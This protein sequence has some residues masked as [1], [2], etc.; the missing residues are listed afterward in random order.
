M[1]PFKPQIRKAERKKAKMRLG[2]IGVSGS[3]KTFS[4][5]QIAFGMGGKV[6]LIDTE[7]G[8]GELYSHMGD[9]DVITLEPPYTT[10]KYRDAMKA[11][12]DAGYGTI[13]LD[14][15]THAWSG[16]GGLLEKQG[17]LEASGKYK[18]SYASWREITPEHNLFIEEMLNSPCNVIATM[19]AKTEYSLEKDEKGR[20]VPRKVGLAPVQ[21]DGME[22][23][24]TIVLDIQDNHYCKASK[25]RTGI[26]GD[27]IFIPSIKAGEQILAWFNS[28]AE[29]K[30][31][32]PKQDGITTAAVKE[33]METAKVPQISEE[34]LIANIE[35]RAQEAAEQGGETLSELWKNLSAD[36]KRRL[37]PFG[38]KFRKIANEVDK[39]KEAAPINDELPGN[40]G[41]EAA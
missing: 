39:K 10:Q 17:K 40:L 6:G 31:P 4:A 19:R 2:L 41:G 13:I 26:F 14:S 15:I 8:S 23:E 27:E 22:Y 30:K 37:I 25:D 18:N 38:T 24:F 21:R 28:G 12:E 33:I 3:G 5:L 20:V 34:Q 16:E 32:E 1:Q 7:H 29:L 35:T 11:F 9:Y 36:E